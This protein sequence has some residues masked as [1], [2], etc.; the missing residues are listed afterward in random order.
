MNVKEC[1]LGKKD[2]KDIKSYI[3]TNDNNVEVEI[4]NIGCA[5]T[6]FMVPDSSGKQVNIVLG[7]PN[8]E[9]Y[10]A[11]GAYFGIVVGRVAGRIDEDKFTLDGKEYQLTVNN[12]PNSLH[13]GA[14]GFSHKIWDITKVST[15]ES[16]CSVALT[17]RSCDGE[18]GYPGTMDI[19]VEY[20]LNNDNELILNYSAECDKKSIVNLTNH[21]YFNLKGTGTILDHGVTI[22]SEK[23][24]LSNKDLIPT[25]EYMAVKGTPFD[26]RKERKVGQSIAE[27]NPQLKIA[28]GYD[29]AF[30]LDNNGKLKTCAKVTA[31]DAAC[32]LEV[33]TDAPAVLFYTGNYLDG[34][35]GNE[36]YVDNAG[37]CLETQNYPNAINH[38]DFPSS[39]IEPGTVW[40]TTTI[41]RV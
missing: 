39:V 20:I 19:T 23:I 40:K 34:V 22:A 15:E 27:D 18:E 2:G 16:Q 10:I 17:Y 24:L 38:P 25:G 36:E 32:T 5:I 11:N 33:D 28:K 30:I 9:D 13:G 41:F 31:D 6:K 26:F 8:W 35:K 21:T 4:L 1:N 29:H 7:Y 14:E 3:I 37:L 12:P